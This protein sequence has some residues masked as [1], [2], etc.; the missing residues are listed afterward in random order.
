[1]APD[2]DA[3]TVRGDEAAPRQLGVARGAIDRVWER[4]V[5]AYRRGLYPAMQV[6]VRYQGRVLIDRAIGY[7]SGAG[8][9]DSPGAE[10]VPVSLDTPFCIFSASKAITTMLIHKLDER[11]L[12]HVD[13]RVCE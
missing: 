7:A 5:A 8:P 11:G 12:L 6:C 9:D 1:M 13:D 4:V 10:R 3:A 2:P